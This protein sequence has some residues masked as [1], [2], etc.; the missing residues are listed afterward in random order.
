MSKYDVLN[1][2]Y[3]ICNV[4]IKNRF[5][6]IP[7]TMGGLSYDEQGGFSENLIHYFE[8]R[9]QGGFGLIIPGAAGT[10]SHVDPYSALGPLVTNPHWQ[11]KP[12]NW[13]K[14]YI[15]GEQ[16]FSVRSPWV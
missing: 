3:K 14:E 12:R 5:T 8:L 9:A 4:E 16:R 13:L 1:Q 6:V 7:M 2:P 15:N 10:D 11:E